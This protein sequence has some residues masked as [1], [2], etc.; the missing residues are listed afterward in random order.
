M[1]DGRWL[2]LYSPKKSGQNS[3]VADED[4]RRHA[5]RKTTRK[6]STVH[7]LDSVSSTCFT[8]IGQLPALKIGTKDEK[9]PPDLNDL[10]L[11]ILNNSAEMPDGETGQLCSVWDIQK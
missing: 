6:L 8:T 11:L 10:N 4:D 2:G 1:W 7:L 9:L 3:G 5:C